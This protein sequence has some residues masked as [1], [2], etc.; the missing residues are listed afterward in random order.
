M[1]RYGLG[2]FTELLL[3]DEELQVAFEDTATVL[4]VVRLA[5][6][7]GCPVTRDEAEDLFRSMLAEQID[8]DIGEMALQE[9]TGGCDYLKRA[10]RWDELAHLA[11][12]FGYD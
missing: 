10:E 11:S 5:A 4:D 6:R 2:R 1:S 12:K 8:P 7:F 3:V 9:L